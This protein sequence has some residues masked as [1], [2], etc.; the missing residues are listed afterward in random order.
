MIKRS[1]IVR[2][3]IAGLA[4]G[5]VY[6]LLVVI[7]GGMVGPYLGMLFASGPMV[8]AQGIVLGLVYSAIEQGIPGRFM[9]LRGLAYGLVVWVLAWFLP[10][11]GGQASTAAIAASFLNSLL[12]SSI[13][14][15]LLMGLV[16]VGVFGQL[17]RW[18]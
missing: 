16:V 3:L 17:R 13:L 6:F 5:V 1:P 11:L 7:L 8:I 2:G 12:D 10:Y 14:G 15:C 4:A 9:L 18:Q